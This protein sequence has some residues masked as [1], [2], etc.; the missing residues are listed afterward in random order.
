MSLQAGMDSELVLDD[1]HP[2]VQY[3]AGVW[4]LGGGEGEY[5][6]TT[7]FTNTTGATV[8]VDFYGE[9]C[10]AYAGAKKLK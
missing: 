8:T 3:A 6:A 9:F 10:S 1:R 7:M 5:K 2:A 4:F